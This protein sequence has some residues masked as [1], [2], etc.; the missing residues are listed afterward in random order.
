VNFTAPDGTART[1]E[2]AG[3]P[4][5]LPVPKRPATTGQDASTTSVL[6]LRLIV[7]R[8]PDGHRTPILT[9]RTDPSASHVAYRIATHW[10][11]EKYFKYAR[12]HLALD[13]LDSYSDQPD[14]LDRPVPNPPQGPRPDPGRRRPRRRRRRPASAPRSKRHGSR[15][16]NLVATGRQP[17]TPPRRRPCP[18]PKTTWLPPKPRPAQPSATD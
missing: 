5:D 2:L 13:G 16:A 12:E 4:I 17:L 9:N 1:Y 15:P 10:R 7:R 11:Q 18:R 3:C 6:T 8:S 14:D